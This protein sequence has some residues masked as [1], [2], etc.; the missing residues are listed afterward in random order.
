MILHLTVLLAI[1]KNMI[2]TT[3]LFILADICYS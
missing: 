1:E 2:S 3:L